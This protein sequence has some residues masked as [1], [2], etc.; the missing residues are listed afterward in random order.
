MTPWFHPAAEQEIAA[1]LKVGEERG[2]GLGQEL[3]HEI[4]RVTT[5]L[6]DA[7]KIGEPLDSRHR[8]FPLR[9]FPF[10]LVYHWTPPHVRADGSAG[11]QGGR[12]S[13]SNYAF[14]RSAM[15]QRVRVASVFGYCAVEPRIM[16]QC[17]AAERGR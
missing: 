1:A 16:R 10:G 17:A 8:R 2:F 11:Y 7:P 9:R 3:I 12:V 4:Q 6:C 5:L 13:W 15:R 14:E